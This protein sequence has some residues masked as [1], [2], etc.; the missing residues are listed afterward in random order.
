MP[1]GGSL[2]ISLSSSDQYFGVSFRDTGTGI[3]PEDFG[4]IFEPS[5]TT[6]PDGSGLGLMIVQ[7]IV[8]DHGGQIEVVS[9]PEAGTSITMLLPLAEKRIR[10]LKADGQKNE[11][12]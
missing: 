7:R 1:D 8:Q 4:H 11:R 3:K 12:R 9:K 6:K 5:F 2:K 10:L